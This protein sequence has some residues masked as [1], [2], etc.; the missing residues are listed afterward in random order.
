MAFWPGLQPPALLYVGNTCSVQ[1]VIRLEDVESYETHSSGVN[2]YAYNQKHSFTDFVGESGVAF[3]SNYLRLTK[4]PNPVGDSGVSSKPSFRQ[5]P[6]LV[7]EKASNPLLPIEPPTKPSRSKNGLSAR[8]SV[9]PAD[10]LAF[11]SI[12][13][14]GGSSGGLSTISDVAYKASCIPL[15]LLTRI[16]SFAVAMATS[17]LQAT[18]F[19]FQP[20]RAFTKFIAY[21]VPSKVV[22]GGI[23]I[24][25]VFLSPYPRRLAFLTIS[26]V[27][28]C[29]RLQHIP[30][31][32][33]VGII[34]RNTYVNSNEAGE[35]KY[36][37]QSS[38]RL[39]P[40]H[41][42]PFPTPNHLKR[43]SV[44]GEEAL[45][46]L[47]ST[48]PVTDMD[49][50]L[51][52]ASHHDAPWPS[53]IS[54]SVSG[55]I[56]GIRQRLAWLLLALTAYRFHSAATSVLALCMAPTTHPPYLRTSPSSNAN[57]TRRDHNTEMHRELKDENKITPKRHGLVCLGLWIHLRVSMSTLSGAILI[58]GSQS[59][60]TF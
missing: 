21:I 25:V 1:V 8:Q 37:I 16:L 32:D 55:S 6:V 46:N 33:S 19:G 31:D 50:N 54:W 53:S 26:V 17:S 30:L 43:G 44:E 48:R 14:D 20:P 18:P 45:Q 23:P 47:H 4:K 24:S 27:Y 3:L 49:W 29:Y 38:T 15:L 51:R 57:A 58:R 13:G 39:F 12:T 7:N 35:E 34:N 10:P 9:S 36:V 28:L 59:Q 2:I 41:G 60:S 11:K 56:R 40:I 5:S 42:N 52:E 22:F